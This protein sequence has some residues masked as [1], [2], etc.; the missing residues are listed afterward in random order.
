V[1]IR[2]ALPQIDG[3]TFDCTEW[4]PVGD[5]SGFTPGYVF[6]IVAWRGEG[7]L[8]QYTTILTLDE[9]KMNPG[10]AALAGL[11]SAKIECGI[12]SLI[13]FIK[14]TKK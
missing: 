9:L 1:L 13:D 3:W 7:E 10:G 12:A 11:L 4:R 5:E 8:A 2:D 14:N 6:T